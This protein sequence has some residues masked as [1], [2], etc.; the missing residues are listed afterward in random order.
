[1]GY[2]EDFTDM[3]LPGGDARAELYVGW[4][5]DEVKAPGTTS[6]AILEALLSAKAWNQLPDGSLD[7]HD[8]EICDGESGHGHFFIDDTNCRY[9]LPNLVIHYITAHHYKLPAEVEDALLNDRKPT[10]LL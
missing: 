9:I 10:R 6:S 8:C 3:T 7:S 2:I 5:G 4:L 1:M